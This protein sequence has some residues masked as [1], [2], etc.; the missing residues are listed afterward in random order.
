MCP[1]AV[2]VP[3]GL[4]LAVFLGS[5]ITCTVGCPRRDLR[6]FRFQL[7]RRICLSPST[8]TPFNGEFRIPAAV[9][10]LRP[11]I[12]PHGS[13]GMSTVSAIGLAFR[14]ILRDRL[15]PGR[16]TLP[17]KPWPFGES[18]SHALYRYLYLHLLFQALQHG[19]SPCL[20]RTCNAPLPIS[21][22]RG[23]GGRFNTR[24]L[25]THNPSTSELLRT[26]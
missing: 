21:R 1:F 17:G 24:L 8:P 3:H 9:S 4:S 12:A 22:S 5:L 14:R 10:L 19:S 2:R 20:R 23:F 13:D 25:S 11:R 26:L 16:L 18:A 6:T 7:G 15:T